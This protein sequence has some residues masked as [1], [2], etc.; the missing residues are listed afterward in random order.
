VDRVRGR[1]Q[2]TASPL[3]GRSPRRVDP[4]WIAGLAL[5]G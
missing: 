5:V 2:L 1:R 4:G 3:R